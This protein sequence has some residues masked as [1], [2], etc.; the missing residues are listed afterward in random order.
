MFPQTNGVGANW[1]A[2]DIA[3][4]H[5]YINVLRRIVSGVISG[6]HHGAESTCRRVSDIGRVLQ[7]AISGSPARKS[8]VP[9]NSIACGDNTEIV[10]RHVFANGQAW[11]LRRR[12]C[13]EQKQGRCQKDAFFHG[14]AKYGNRRQ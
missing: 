12:R 5:F 4:N 10:D 2:A 14:T 3:I 1:D 9:R 13:N 8:P 7:G 6:Y 11:N